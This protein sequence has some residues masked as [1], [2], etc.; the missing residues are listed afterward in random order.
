MK[1]VVNRCFGGFGLSIAGMKAVMA[2]KGRECYAFT[3]YP[4]LTPKDGDDSLFCSFYD[5]SNAHELSQEDREEHY[6]SYRDFDRNDPDLVAVVES[7]GKDAN[8][9]CADLEVVEIPDGIQ[10]HVEDYDGNEHIA[11]DHRTW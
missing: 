3:G 2:R 6:I 7:L 11:E 1:V 4:V 10:W 5:V 8:E 9:S